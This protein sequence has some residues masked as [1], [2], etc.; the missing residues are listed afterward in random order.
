MPLTARTSGVSG[1]QAQTV[2]CVCLSI[3]F[4]S[5]SDLFSAFGVEM[6]P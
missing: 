1:L 4:V 5:G 2:S 6:Q 3:L